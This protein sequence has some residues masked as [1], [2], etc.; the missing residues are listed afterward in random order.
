METDHQ[1]ITDAKYW[2]ILKCCKLFSYSGKIYKLNQLF[3]S[4]N[5]N[6]FILQQPYYVVRNTN[7]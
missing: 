1:E 5:K 3:N 2:D 7:T 4:S 6:E